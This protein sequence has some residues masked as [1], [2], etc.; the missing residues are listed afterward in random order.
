[1]IIGI[2]GKK[3]SGKDTVAKIIQYLIYKH[4]NKYIYKHSEHEFDI[5]KL[6]SEHYS[7]Q[8]FKIVR[9]AELP[10]NIVCMITNCTREQLEDEEFKNEVLGEEWWYYEFAFTKIPYNKYNT[11]DYKNILDGI[12]VK[13]T[14]RMLLQKIGTDCGRDIIHPNIWVNTVMSNYYP[15]AIKNSTDCVSKW[16]IPD[17][18]F[19]NEL[20]A[21]QERSGIVIRVNRTP[22]H[23][24]ESLG[25]KLNIDEDF[26]DAKLAYE[27]PSETSLDNAKFDYTIDNNGI[28][29]ELI[30]KVK[31]IL[32]DIKLI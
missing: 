10:K 11:N 30:Y 3:Q 7:N 16:I 14:R 21:I 4:N 25:G 9:F 19:P 32:I 8:P 28:I 18:R 27:H 20:Q 29:E 26:K 5:F 12:L 24:I 13:P 22:R 31:D 15:Y 6:N 2:S 1:M 23:I 17:V